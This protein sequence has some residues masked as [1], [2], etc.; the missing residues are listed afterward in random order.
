MTDRKEI[1]RLL[2][3]TGRTLE[4]LPKLP[5]YR[6]RG[7]ANTT[8]AMGE[9]GITETIPFMIHQS[10]VIEL[11]IGA[12]RDTQEKFDAALAD[13]NKEEDCG[14]CSHEK[15]FDVCT[16]SCSR[17]EKDC[18]CKLC[19]K[20]ERGYEWRGVVRQDTKAK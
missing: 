2:N 14:N 8:K 16:V 17:C 15:P 7:L 4:G 1:E 19:L 3:L 11:L 6:G 9:S 18:P 5:E 10:D 13:L 12:L 20:G